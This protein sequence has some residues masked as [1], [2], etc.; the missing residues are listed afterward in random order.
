MSQQEAREDLY[1]SEIGDEDYGF[2]FGPDGELK[3]VFMP[4]D[5]DFNVPEQVRNVFELA[6]I[7]NPLAVQVHTIH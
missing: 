1:D 4:T 2:I 7:P 6:G 5:F 3:A